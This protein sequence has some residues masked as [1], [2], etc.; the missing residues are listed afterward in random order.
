MPFRCVWPTFYVFL[1]S[2]RKYFRSQILLDSVVFCNWYSV[3]VCVCVCV[4]FIVQGDQKV[5]V[6]LQYKSSGA[7][8]LFDYPVYFTIFLDNVY[9]LWCIT[10]LDLWTM[11]TPLLHLFC[12]IDADFHCT[13]ISKVVSCCCGRTDRSVHTEFIGCPQY[14]LAAICIIVPLILPDHS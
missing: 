9:I 1:D 5:S 7:Q 4:F 6:R 12:M 10:L 13:L 11:N 3:C 2:V 8:R 14:V